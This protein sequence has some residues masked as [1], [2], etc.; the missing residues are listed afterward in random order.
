[1]LTEIKRLIHEQSET[2]SKDRKYIKKDQTETLMLNNSIIELKI[3]LENFKSR[4]NQ[5]EQR[6]IK[7]KEKTLEKIQG[8]KI[9][10]KRKEYKNLKNL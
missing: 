10:K 2:F 6:T 1:M 3:S 7:L 8:V 4:L 5:A 9:S